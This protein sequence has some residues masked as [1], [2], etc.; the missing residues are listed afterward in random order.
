MI[1]LD[2]V[3]RFDPEKGFIVNGVGTSP[4]WKSTLDAANTSKY[5]FKTGEPGTGPS[6]HTSF[7]LKDIPAIHFFTGAHE[8]Y[9]RPTDDA[10]KINY[11]GIIQI[12]DFILNVIGELNPKLKLAFTRTKDDNDTSVPNFKVTLG[13]IPD[14]LFDGKGMRVEGV[15]EDRPASTAGILAGDII[16]K[17]GDMEVTNMQTYMEGLSKFDKGSKTVVRVKRGDKDLDLEVQF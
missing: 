15:K 10:D 1:N 14:Y 7:Y 6:D 2:M 11:A 9:H 17:M 8:D 5:K 16:V 13:V 12:S 3:G 4:I